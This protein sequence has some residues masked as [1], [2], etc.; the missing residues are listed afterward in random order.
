M[1]YF[2]SLFLLIFALEVQ[3]QD[4]RL[5]GLD[6]FINRVLKEW[7]AVGVSVAV[8][9]KNKVLL[10]KGYG[11][12]DLDKKLPVTD[13][14]LFAIGS[15]TKAFTST[16]LGMLVNEGKLDLDKPVN[17][18]IPGLRFYNDALTNQVTTRDMMSHRTGYQGMICRGTVLPSPAI[19]L[20]IAFVTSNHLLRF[21]RN[22]ST[23]ISC[24]S[25]KDIWP[26]S[27]QE[28]PGKNY[29]NRK[30]SRRWV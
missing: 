20:S 4:K 19:V 23:I 21:A 15:C 18:Y 30:F 13:E 27:S 8:V 12:R 16:L 28:H 1:K 3:A 5:A 26:S 10:A 14:T 22:G 2:V 7:K 24:S 29:C 17:Q 9:E 6:T 25:R 11:Y